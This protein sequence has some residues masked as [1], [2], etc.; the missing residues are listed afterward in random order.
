MVGTVP[1]SL[2]ELF[3]TLIYP[4]QSS[5]SFIMFQYR[6][7]RLIVG[8]LAGPSL[9]IAGAIFQGVLRNPLASTDVVGI[10]QGAGFA[11]CIAILVFPNRQEGILPFIA[12]I[13]AFAVGVT[14]FLM[15]RKSRF[16]T[17]TIALIGVALGALCDAGIQFLTVNYQGDIHTALVWLTGSLWGRHW[18]E[19]FIIL[20]FS[21]TFILLALI[22]SRK[23]DILALGEIL[24]INLGENI[25]FLTWGFLSLA[26]ALSA[27]TVS[28]TGTIGFI[29]LLAPHMAKS[30]IGHKHIHIFHLSGVI[31]AILLITADT[32][33]RWIF[34]PV[35]I[36]AG[37][38]T[39]ILGAP[40]FMYLLF[41]KQSVVGRK[42]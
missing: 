13:G 22:F 5:H 36:P 6:I 7:P 31:G 23:M 17:S 19:V 30:I 37:I 1:I 16:N 29:G 2:G 9:A 35:E 15:N 42:E 11:T 21:I 3:E 10:T 38:I 28:V 39:A 27:S 41:K 12:M 25:K 33:G 24:A 40:Y 26:I 14:L 18:E 34:A 4:E 8:L 20:P 32:L